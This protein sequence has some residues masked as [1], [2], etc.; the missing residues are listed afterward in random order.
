MPYERYFCFR[1]NHSTTHPLPAITAKIEELMTQ[2][3]FACEVF[4]DLKKA[5]DTVN[6]DVLLKTPEYFEINIV[7]SAL[8][9]GTSPGN[10]LNFFSSEDA[11]LSLFSTVTLLFHFSSLKSRVWFLFYFKYLVHY[12]GI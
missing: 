2:G 7:S 8:I 1:H 5:F 12:N 3:I 6:N 10:E 9:I 4:L 11:L